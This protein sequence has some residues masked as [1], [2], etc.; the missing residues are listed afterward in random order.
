MRLIRLVDVPL[1]ELWDS[2]S[3]ILLILL[4][5]FPRQS[6]LSPRA[7]MPPDNY[8]F[9]IYVITALPSRVDAT[10]GRTIENASTAPLSPRAW[11]PQQQQCPRPSRGPLSPARVD[12]PERLQ[13]QIGSKSSF[14]RAR[15]YPGTSTG[16]ISKMRDKLS[17]GADAGT[18]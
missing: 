11:M 9:F 2:L 6:P 3:L 4:W 14:P 13:F 12:T 18:S 10:A 17:Q 15:G 7:W 16:R 8:I 1:G 5:A